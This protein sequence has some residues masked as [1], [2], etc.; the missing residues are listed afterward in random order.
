MATFVADAKS[1]ASPGIVTPAAWWSTHGGADGEVARTMHR[2]AG[3]I[4]EML[5][6]RRVSKEPLYLRREN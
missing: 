6:A 3:A 2:L 1:E 4:D 5:A